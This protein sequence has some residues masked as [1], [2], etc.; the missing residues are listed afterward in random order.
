MGIVSLQ[1]KEVGGWVGIVSLQGKEVGG[2][3][4]TAG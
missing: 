1:G 2:D 3:S 4:L